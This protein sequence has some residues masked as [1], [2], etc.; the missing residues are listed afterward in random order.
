MIMDSQVIV[1]C[2]LFVL[3]IIT[4]NILLWMYGYANDVDWY[5]DNDL[6]LY[7]GKGGGRLTTL[8]YL[9]MP[10]T[11]FTGIHQVVRAAAWHIAGAGMALLT[12]AVK[13]LFGLETAGELFSYTIVPISGIMGIMLIVAAVRE[14]RRTIRA[15]KDAISIPEY[16]QP[17][18]PEKPMPRPHVYLDM[19]GVQCDFDGAVME[20]IQSLTGKPASYEQF[21]EHLLDLAKNPDSIRDL[22][23]NLRPLTA[24]NEIVAFLREHNIP[25]TILSSPMKNGVTEASID[26][27]L[28]WLSKYTPGAVENALFVHDKHQYAVS[29]DGSPNILIDDYQKKIALWEAAGGIAIHQTDPDSGSHTIDTLK[30]IFDLE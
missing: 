19:D 12:I 28:Q 21:E 20:Q 4:G 11:R 3:V 5:T 25:Y 9:F 1:V 23:A 7:H 13:R 2:W 8:E 10:S 6:E 16:H 14:R 29:P 18:Y 22:F 24:G 15:F 27:K 26:G 30:R 17:P